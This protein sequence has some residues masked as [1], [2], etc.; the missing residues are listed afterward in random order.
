MSP[1]EPTTNFEDF[2]ESAY[3]KLVRAAKER[4]QFIG[5]ADF[6]E[7]NHAVLWRHDV[8]ISPQRAL[9]LAKIEKEEGVRSTYFALAHSEFYNLLEGPVVEMFRQIAA[10]GHDIGLHFDP[11]FYK[12]RISSEA[13]LLESLSF[14]KALL[15]RMLGVTIGAF[16]WHNPTTGDWPAK[17]DDRVAGMINA[18]GVS[19]H[20]RYRY[21]SDSNGIWRHDRLADVIAAGTA[22]CLHVLTHPE[23]WVS[24]PSA[25]RDRVL[26][27]IKGRAEATMANYDRALE[28]FGRPNIGD[29]KK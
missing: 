20:A 18:Y 6:A 26:R 9:A 29:R 14:E 15:E 25:P 13:A 27:A 19:I 5:F 16:S 2:T 23:W 21:V 17:S 1:I 11:D 4:W 22:D 10:L 12:D 24:S 8:D 7:V 28:H 3:R